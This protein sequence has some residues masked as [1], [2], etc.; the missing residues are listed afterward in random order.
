[1]NYYFFNLKCLIVLLLIITQACNN[2]RN[3]SETHNSIKNVE[4]SSE[5]TILENENDKYFEELELRMDSLRQNFK[6]SMQKKAY[7]FTCFKQCDENVT[8]SNIINKYGRKKLYDIMKNIQRDSISIKFS[9]ID[10]CCQEFIGNVEKKGDTL[11]L[12]YEDISGERCDC[13]CAYN[14][15][16]S[17]PL[18]KYF[19]RFIL[20]GDSLIQR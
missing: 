10:A 9:F 2:S 20:L 13:Y 8:G 1:M 5:Q 16:Y 11:K 19:S 7:N 18:T 15:E 14:Y 12:S 6:I 4:D 17:L 3:S